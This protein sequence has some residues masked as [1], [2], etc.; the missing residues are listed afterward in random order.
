MESGPPQHLGLHSHS[1][2]ENSRC[3]YSSWLA[4]NWSEIL[5]I[6]E[7]TIGT[8]F[9]NNQLIDLLIESYS[10]YVLSHCSCVV[11]KA[12]A[13]RFHCWVMSVCSSWNEVPFLALPRLSAPPVL[14]HQGDSHVCYHAFESGGASR[15]RREIG[16]LWGYMWESELE[17]LNGSYLS[18]GAG[19][20]CLSS[21]SV[22]SSQPQTL[23][24]IT[25]APFAGSPAIFIDASLSTSFFACFLTG[26]H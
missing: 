9:K 19:Q 23:A 7:W 17:I 21:G 4:T 20:D 16:R 11:V 22:F 15:W 13:S 25:A 2:W 5:T 26:P 1:T 14:Q 12:G 8:Y 18:F 6:R 10:L 24:E 3:W